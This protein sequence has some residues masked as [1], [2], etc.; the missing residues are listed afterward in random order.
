MRSKDT[1]HQTPLPSW[2]LLLLASLFAVF[3]LANP[4]TIA[5]LRT[6][7]FDDGTYSHAYLMPVVIAYLYWRAWKQQQLVLR[8]NP[9][10]FVL[11]A[12]CLLLFLWLQLAQQALFARVLLPATLILALASIYRV[13]ASLL[14]PA[15]LLWFITPI[16]SLINGILQKISVVA[17]SEIMRWTH[18]P[19]F[20]EGN[21]VHIPA[22]TFEIADGCS[23]LRYFIVSMALGVIFSFLNLKRARSILLF[24]AIAILGS[25]ITNWIRIVLLILIGDYTQMQSSL[26]DDHNMFGWY[27]Y[28]PFIA[29]LFYFG[30]FLDR[31]CATEPKPEPAVTKPCSA[32]APVAVLSCLLV[33]STLSTNLLNQQPQL[34]PIAS[35]D[36]DGARQSDS[37]NGISP[38]IFAAD[39][40]Q[41]E[42]LQLGHHILFVQRYVFF[43]HN[44]ASRS[45]YYLNDPVPVGWQVLQQQ[46]LEDSALLKIGSRSGQTAMI[47]YWHQIG[48]HRTASGLQ[49]RQYRLQQALRLNQ[50]TEL[51]WFLL[52]CDQIDCQE[53]QQKIRNLDRI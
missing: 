26:M 10:F 32:A 46:T 22:G 4:S 27:I 14:I 29:L 49:I 43:G 41:H 48:P 44:D 6:Y 35:I 34:Y 19:T 23:G 38:Q 53:E 36:V 39:T 17:V 51:H 21:Y 33:F 42:Q 40:W 15:S 30:S 9:Y 2:P 7:S 13:N 5:D 16:W 50:V 1:E 45:N 11:F 25:L 18:V 31:D 12:G 52:Y 20:V 47:R 8:W 28:V 37:F 24:F 3:F